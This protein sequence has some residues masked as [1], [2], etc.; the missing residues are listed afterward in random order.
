VSFSNITNQIF[1]DKSKLSHGELISCSYNL[2]ENSVYPHEVSRVF[3]FESQ[4]F[5]IGNLPP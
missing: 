1:Q 4:S 5:N 3:Q 2:G